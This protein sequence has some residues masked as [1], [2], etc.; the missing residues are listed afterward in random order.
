MKKVLLIIVVAALIFG[1]WYCGKNWTKKKPGTD[2]NTTAQ[3]ST[4]AT[5]ANDNTYGE[6]FIFS[7][8]EANPGKT[9]YVRIVREGDNPDG[10]IF[11]VKKNLMVYVNFGP[12]GQVQKYPDPILV[13][14][15]FWKDLGAGIHPDPAKPTYEV[16]YSV[17]Q[18]DILNSPSH[19]MIQLIDQNKY[20]INPPTPPVCN[21]P[22]CP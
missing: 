2:T 12:K 10:Q 7:G 17:A 13:K 20:V 4:S 8:T 15:S 5:L 9:D 1:A 18:S 19:L 6:V 14:F 3:E 16:S 21:Y 11:P 22:V